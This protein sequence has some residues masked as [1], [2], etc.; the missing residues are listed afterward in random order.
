MLVNLMHPTVIVADGTFV[1]PQ[2]CNGGDLADY[3]QGKRC[4]NMK[5]TLE[6]LHHDKLLVLQ[7]CHVT[8]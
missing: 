8:E 4:C 6:T 2:Y 3:L 1:F 7:D 5:H